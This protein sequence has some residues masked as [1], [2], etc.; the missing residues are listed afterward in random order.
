M[1]DEKLIDFLGLGEYRLTKAGYAEMDRMA[2]RL[3]YH[4]LKKAMKEYPI[5]KNLD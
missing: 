3:P 1:R 5:K 4:E 2:G